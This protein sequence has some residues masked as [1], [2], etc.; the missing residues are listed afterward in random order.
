MKT[1][2]IFSL[3]VCVVA[4][5]NVSCT[6]H[7]K[8]KNV[9]FEEKTPADWENQHV[10]QINKEEPRASFIPYASKEKA[11]V[12]NK[13]ESSLLQ[14]LNGKWKFHLSKNPS[15]RPYYFFKFWALLISR[16]KGV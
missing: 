12:D 14:S 2:T 3:V 8:Y 10:F 11:I 15:E 6:P 13:W 5:M 4:M 16:D 9:A 1:Q 7:N